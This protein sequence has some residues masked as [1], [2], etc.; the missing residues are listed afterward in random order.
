MKQRNDKLLQLGHRVSDHILV[1]SLLQ[2]WDLYLEAGIELDQGTSLRYASEQ[3]ISIIIGEWERRRAHGQ[4]SCDSFPGD[5]V[6]LD[7]RKS[8]RWQESREETDE[9]PKKGRLTK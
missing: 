2:S 7:K 5:E 3:L 8:L 1:T 4:L 6:G 9:I